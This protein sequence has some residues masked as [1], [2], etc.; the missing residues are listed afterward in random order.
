LNTRQTVLLLALW[1]A[2]GCGGSGSDALGPDE[3]SFTVQD[4]IRTSE[5][6]LGAGANASV[7]GVGV[8]GTLQGSLCSHTVT[9]TGRVSRSSISLTVEVR[10]RADNPICPPAESVIN[11]TALFDDLTCG[12]T[13]TVRVVHVQ[14]PGNEVTTPFDG[15]VRS[16][17]P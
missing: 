16:C 4:H 8:G 1:S 14:Q 13:Y 2:T 15:P 7:V 9:P 5:D 6:Q 17:E 11:Y 3:L 12:E 10:P